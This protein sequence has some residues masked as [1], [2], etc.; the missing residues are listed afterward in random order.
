MVKDSIFRPIYTRKEQRLNTGYD[1]KDKIM[2]NSISSYMFGV[3]DNLD[4][5]I[6]F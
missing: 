6:G 3:N 1:Y 5:F 4:Y 2:K